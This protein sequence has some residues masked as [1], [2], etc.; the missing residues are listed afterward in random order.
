VKKY[1]SQGQQKSF[2][3]ALRL[4]QYEYIA[5][6]CQKKPVLLLGDIFDKL[7]S[8]RILKLIELVSSDFFG[9]V[10]ITD[11]ENERLELIF[12]ARNAEFRIFDILTLATAH[13]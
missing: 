11:T 2:V 3:I 5:E 13:E 4:A 12:K 9:Q 6:I 7:D 10:I 8:T 1:G